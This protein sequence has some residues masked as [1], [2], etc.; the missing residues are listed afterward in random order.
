[1]SRTD[2]TRLAAAMLDAE[3]GAD[4]LND[5]DAAYAALLRHNAQR[6]SRCLDVPYLPTSVQEY[7]NHTLPWLRHGRD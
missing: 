7:R 5:D 4:W 6:C 3:N 1:M 2:D